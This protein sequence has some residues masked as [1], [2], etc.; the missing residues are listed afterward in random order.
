[1]TIIVIEE[2]K[3]K[4][5]PSD[6]TMIIQHEIFSKCKV[7]INACMLSMILHMS[8]ISI[9]FIMFNEGLDTLYALSD[10]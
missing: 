6:L 10:E 5:I 8:Q 7:A 9:N 3:I 1:M 4:F 2:V